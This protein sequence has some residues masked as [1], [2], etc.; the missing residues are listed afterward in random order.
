MENEIDRDLTPHKK[1]IVFICQLNDRVYSISKDGIIG[2]WS[3][4]ADD[5]QPR[6]KN[7]V[8]FDFRRAIHKR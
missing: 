5:F 6:G 7:R 3:C 1:E 4:K 8:N 2:C